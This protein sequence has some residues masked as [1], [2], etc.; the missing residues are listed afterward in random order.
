MI[1][2][3]TGKAENSMSYGKEVTGDYAKIPRLLSMPTISF[4]LAVLAFGSFHIFLWFYVR[5]QPSW[6]WF[7][8]LI[9]LFSLASFLTG[10]VWLVRAITGKKA[11]S[12]GHAFVIGGFLILAWILLVAPTTPVRTQRA[13]RAAISSRLNRIHSAMQIYCNENGGR[14]PSAE[15]WA[16]LLLEHDKQLSVDDFRYPRGKYGVFVFSLNRNIAGMRFA[17]VSQDTVLVFECDGT[18]NLSG[19]PELVESKRRPIVP[20]SVKRREFFVLKS[21]GAILYAQVLDDGT[22]TPQLQWGP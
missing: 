4:M 20:V 5:M 14:L 11:L 1:K 8:G 15:Q 17:D 16:D 10:F 2:T 12:I 18:W 21:S 3:H 6:K 9:V 19:G 7:A 13:K 22:V